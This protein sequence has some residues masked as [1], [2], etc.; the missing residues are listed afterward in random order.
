[1]CNYWCQQGRRQRY[2]KGK[3]TNLIIYLFIY[4]SI[5][6]SIYLAT[7]RQRSIPGPAGKWEGGSIYLFIYLATG[8]QRSIPST[9]GKRKGGS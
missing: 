9:T 7:G 6:L 1:M 4:L 3:Q 8:R 2:C 5:Y